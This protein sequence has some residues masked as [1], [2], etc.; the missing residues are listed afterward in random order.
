MFS[1]PRHQ[2]WQAGQWPFASIGTELSSF[3]KP[4]VFVGG[5]KMWKAL[6]MWSAGFRWLKVWM[7]CVWHLKLINQVLC[8]NF[9]FNYIQ[10]SDVTCQL[11][12][13]DITYSCLIT[14]QQSSDTSVGSDAILDLQQRG[15]KSYRPFPFEPN[16]DQKC[17]TT[18]ARRA[19]PC[20]S[21]SKESGG[22]VQQPWNNQWSATL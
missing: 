18:P 16:L 6:V 5:K 2:I 19:E 17:S 8:Q 22:M 1:F 21:V 9:N 14:W 10:K 15:N 12:L 3:L 7:W 20:W 11:T 4:P 13:L